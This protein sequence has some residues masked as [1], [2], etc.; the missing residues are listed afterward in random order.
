VAALGLLL[1]AGC[2]HDPAAAEAEAAAHRAQPAA[3]DVDGQRRRQHETM[4][5]AVAAADALSL[6]TAVAAALLNSDTLAG[7]DAQV[8]AALAQRRQIGA[9]VQPQLSLDHDYSQRERREADGLGFGGFDTTHDTYVLLRQPIYSGLQNIAANDAA[10]ARV[11]NRVAARQVLRHQIALDTVNAY[12]SLLLAQQEQAILQTTVRV[13]EAQTRDLQ[14]RV[15]AGDVRP[16]DMHLARTELARL[17]ADE[18][19]A[20]ETVATALEVLR[21][22]TGLAAFGALSPPAETLE[23][24]DSEVLIAQALARHPALDDLRYQRQ[25]YE[26]EAR[27]YRRQ[28]QPDIDLEAKVYADRQGFLEDVRWDFR[29]TASLPLFE[30][31]ARVGRVAEAEANGRAAQLALNAMERAIARDIRTTLAALASTD[32]IL[33]SRN[34]QL[35]AATEALHH[36]TREYELGSGTQLEL[37]A[38]RNRLTEAQLSGEREQLRRQYLAFRLRVETGDFPLKQEPQSDEND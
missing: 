6:P 16:A 23:I 24:A 7:A 15:E 30:G 2:A 18:K 36:I 32:A 14:K 22:E 31:G 13:Q 28:A 29:V 4:A 25:A 10:D 34:A 38:S 3:V 33:V 11:A 5:A 9:S 26:A 8:A 27:L 20:A 1:Q 19:R 17:Q 21:H 35:A 12:F 37:L